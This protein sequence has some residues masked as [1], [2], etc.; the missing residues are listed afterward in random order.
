MKKDNEQLKRVAQH[1]DEEAPDYD[2]VYTHPIQLAED[3]TLMG[4]LAPHVAQGQKV[5]D[6]GCGT[7]L[8]LQYLDIPQYQ[9]IDV[10]AGMIAQARR[11]HPGKDFQVGDMHELPAKDE[12]VDTV[13][14]LFGPLSYSHAPQQAVDEMQ[15]VLKPGGTAIVMP[16]TERVGHGLDMGGYST[17][18]ADEIK[19]TYHGR[20]SAR[21]LFR[22]FHSVDAKGFNYFAN[23]LAQYDQAMQGGLSQEDYE[24]YLQHE[25]DHSEGM[26]DMK[27]ARHGLVIA[28]KGLRPPYRRRKS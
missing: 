9:G 14:S 16:Y 8:P 10:S 11:H 27:Y 7:G 17:A 28:R 24:R 3:K 2:G 6:V 20:D 18:V 5:L 23:T 4:V 19:K 26:P 21:R 15:R 12:S 13:I 22:K 25:L 1:Y